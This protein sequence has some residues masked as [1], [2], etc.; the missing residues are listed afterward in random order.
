MFKTLQILKRQHLSPK[1][2][3]SM[4]EDLG[5][6]HADQVGEQGDYAHRG[7]LIDVYPP[8]FQSPVRIEL[9][10]DVV[11]SIRSFNP[12]T[13]DM[14]ETHEGIILLPVRSVR[15]RRF[16]LPMGGAAEEVP[17]DTFVDLRKGDY[18]VHVRHGIGRYLGMRRLGTDGEKKSHMVIQYEGN[19]TLYVPSD[20]LHLIQKYIAFEGSRPKLYKLGSKLWQRVKSRAKE[21][22]YRYAHDI[23]ELEATR[24]VMKGFSFAKDTEW[25]RAFESEFPFTETL[26]Q[27]QAMYEVKKDMESVRPM[28]RLLL[29]DVGYGK[30]EVAMRAAFKAV[31]SGKQV[32][33]LVPTT[34]LAEQH[35]ATF[36][37]RVEHF[38]VRVEMLSRFKTPVAQT[39][40]LRDLKEGRVDIIIGT[41]RLLSGDVSFKD[42]GLVII[43]EEQRFGVKDKETLKRMRLVVDV[44]TLSATPIPRTLY[45]SLSGV[46]DMSIINT[47]PEARMPVATRIADF[48][49]L[50]IQQAIKREL[51]RGGQIFFVHNRVRSLGKLA[52]LLE[53]L[54]PGVRIAV[55]HGQMPSRALE[56]VMLGFIAG[57]IRVLL[58]TQIVQSGID[59][60]NANTL[61]VYPA[62]QF[63]L[64][65]LYQLRG[66]VGRFTRKAYAYFLLSP[67]SAL[68]GD[69]QRRLDAIQRHTELGAGFK[70]AM[71][72]L[73]IRGAGNLLGPQQHGFISSVGFDLYCRLLRE[74]IH[75]LRREKKQ[76]IAESKL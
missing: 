73:Q 13:G 36:E 40:I 59:I 4:L 39:N 30:T 38:P 72:D 52:R 64:A 19:D 54:I 75:H 37:R 74:A 6:R 76:P 53:R 20:Q 26:G 7:S 9:D 34:I 57:E 47:P 41:H 21:G 1:E 18:V 68:T 45:M 32:A 44:L 61:I 27:R 24:G 17:I 12:V 16:D 14:F 48:N 69:S 23:L 50:L 8:D 70:I 49:E 63:G 56:E 25:Q 3:C 33:I 71:E 5:Y 51:R 28:D 31:I 2:T 29:G 46:K 66:R 42:L 11:E 60:P 55:A 62:D 67:G 22:V 58:S 65:D 43:D 10:G 15:K 35:Y